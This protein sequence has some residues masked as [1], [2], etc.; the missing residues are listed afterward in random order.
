MM[1]GSLA[2]LEAD[3]ARDLRLIAYPDQ[4]W[5]PPRTHD[6]EPVLDVLIVGAGQGGLALAALLLRERI[7]R[8]EV[9][10]AAPQGEE[11]LWMRFARM[12]TLRTPKH[13]GGPDLNIPSL[14]FQAWFEAQHG[15]D[16]FAQ[17]K[18]IPKEDW[19][20]YLGWFR[21]VLGL[22]VR[23]DVAFC[24]LAPVAGTRDGL[25]RVE[26]RV[27]GRTE[28]RL[29]RKVVLAQ[30]IETSGA[31]WM[32][33]AIARLP[34]TLRAHA[35]E[36]IDFT[37]LA[38]RRVALI[39]AAA[40]AF[41]NAATA[42]E[43]GAAEVRMFC[44]RDALQRVQ[45]YKILA[46]A[47]FLRHFGELPDETRW[48]MMN[49]LLTVREALTRET[50]ERVTIHPNF[51]L[52]TGAEPLAIAAI[53]DDRAVRLTTPAGSFEADFVICGTG[54][55]TDLAL[56]PELDG[57]SGH[58]ARWSDRYEPPAGERNPRIGGYP[59]LD[60]G[61]AFTERV[62]GAAPWVGDVHCFNFG[63][64]LSFGPSGSSISAMKFAVPRVVHAIGRDLF[65]GDIATH[66]ARLRDYD[67][68]E[69][70]F[71]FARDLKPHIA[72][73]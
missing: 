28:F 8:V 62:P 27:E 73:G 35:S 40:S 70:P 52:T 54:F 50:W 3:I 67:T 14:T 22:P 66:E 49:H 33:D 37:R 12:K 51:E 63:A 60:D 16:A 72:S 45:P 21:G 26:L 6:G 30:G 24:G 23:N 5:V 59:Y 9:V 65:R 1:P 11:G 18:Y 57:L 56:R 25:I 68:P 34:S 44:R 47:G 71:V 69:F 10:D 15:P 29:A 53:D 55:T 61:M 2:E 36:T 13:I 20:A 58:V 17:I 19:Q 31:W 42:L 4:P 41:D 38:G 43:H 48:R 7:T 39:G 32:P 46:Y 64:T